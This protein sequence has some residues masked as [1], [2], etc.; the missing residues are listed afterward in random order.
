[1]DGE[2]LKINVLFPTHL[3][4]SGINS[5]LKVLPLLFMRVREPPKVTYMCF[6]CFIG[7]RYF[8]G[9]LERRHMVVSTYRFPLQLS[10]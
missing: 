4:L 10:G 5:F 8:I 1:M 3:L 9:K 2:D 7:N 6:S